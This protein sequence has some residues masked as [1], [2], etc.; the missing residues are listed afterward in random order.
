MIADAIITQIPYILNTNDTFFPS[1]GLNLNAHMNALPFKSDN[2]HIF[3]SVLKGT[4]TPMISMFHQKEL[5][6]P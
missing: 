3:N 1:N 4:A 6:E 2:T 5:Y